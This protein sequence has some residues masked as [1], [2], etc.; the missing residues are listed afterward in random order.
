[1]LAFDS[2][3]TGIHLLN[4]CTTFA[5]GTYDGSSFR[6][7]TVD[8][9]PFTRSR[10]TQHPKTLRKVFDDADL[11]V[12]G[13]FRQAI[14]FVERV[15]ISVRGCHEMVH[16]RIEMQR[17]YKRD[18][19]DETGDLFGKQTFEDFD[20]YRDVVI[21]DGSGGG[22]HAHKRADHEKFFPTKV[23]MTV[24]Q[25]SAGAKYDPSLVPNLPRKAAEVKPAT[26]SAATAV[27]CSA[28]AV[29][30]KP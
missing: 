25:V 5:I 8:I 17:R 11:L 18:E 14:E 21:K 4:G 20:F 7:S 12:L 6:D 22:G 3:T 9:N 23:R 15:E 13:Q 24:I 27:G 10:C 1:M 26:H 2:E 28:P 30:V 19:I 29:P 16:H